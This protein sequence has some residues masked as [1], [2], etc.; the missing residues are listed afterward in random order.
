M[1][2]PQWAKAIEIIYPKAKDMASKPRYWHVAYPLVV[3]SLCVAP[4][5]YFLR[6]WLS[7][8]EFGLSKLKVCTTVL[9]LC[10][11]NL[12]LPDFILIGETIPHTRHERNDATHLDIYVPLPRERLYLDV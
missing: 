11:A 2:H 1:N 4:T 3:V 7:C 10:A 6:H 12:K 5:E 8:F 9:L